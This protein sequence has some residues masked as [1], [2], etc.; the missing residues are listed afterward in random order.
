MAAISNKKPATQRVRD[1]LNGSNEVFST[2]ELEEKLHV[3]T[4][5]GAFKTTS[6]LDEY[7]IL[8]HVG[9]GKTYIWGNKKSLNLYQHYVGANESVGATGSNQ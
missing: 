5:T 3:N 4:R 1:F 8:S 7:K 6:L 2:K 9:N